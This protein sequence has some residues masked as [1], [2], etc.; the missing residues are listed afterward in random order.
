MLQA[1]AVFVMALPG[2]PVIAAAAA[3]S[4]SGPAAGA[5]TVGP[6]TRLPNGLAVRYVSKRDV[7]FLYQEIYQHRCYL[8]HGISLPR[9]G[10]V[11]DI[12]GNIGLFAL[13]AAEELGPEVRPGPGV[14]PPGA[15]LPALFCRC[16]AKALPPPASGLPSRP[17]P[18]QPSRGMP[19]PAPP[20][21]TDVLLPLINIAACSL[22]ANCRAWWCPVSP[23]RPPTTACST[24]P[25]RTAAGGSSCG[26]EKARLGQQHH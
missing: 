3:T 12:G 7:A 8:R 2:R 14:L 9:G 16:K 20:Y 5:P 11:L 17:P 22:D 19:L 6:T 10:T 23:C 1:S 25:P 13:S 15:Q 4:G 21:A 18:S 26:L 24:T